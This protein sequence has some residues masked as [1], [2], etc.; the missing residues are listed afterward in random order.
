MRLSVCVGVG[1][2][3]VNEARARGSGGL[4]GGEYACR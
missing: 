3:V 1:V 2:L 4:T